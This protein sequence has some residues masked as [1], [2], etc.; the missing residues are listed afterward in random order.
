MLLSGFRKLSGNIFT[1]WS[2]IEMDATSI[3]LA[4]V[5]AEVRSMVGSHPLTSVDR[6][7]PSVT[8]MTVVNMK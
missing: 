7:S 3:S 4:E 1:I 8:A 6:P 5:A 2:M